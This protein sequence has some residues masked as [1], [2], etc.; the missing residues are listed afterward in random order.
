M[1][2]LSKRKEEKRKEREEDRKCSK[3]SNEG[4]IKVLSFKNQISQV[5][6]VDWFLGKTAKYL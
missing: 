4:N 6:I 3:E 5:I 1:I 2:D